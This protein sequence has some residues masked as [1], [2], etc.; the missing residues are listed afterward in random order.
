MKTIGVI[1]PN[2]NSGI[3]IKKCL[4]SLLEQEYKVNEIIVVDDCSTDESTKIVK[5]YT[6]K[7]D[8]IILLENGKNMGVSY[9]R[10]RGI[11]NAKSE[12]IMFCDSDDW[13]EKQ[14]TKR[15]M[16]KVEKDSADFVLAGYYIT[17]KDG[18]KIEVKYNNLNKIEIDKETAISY[19]PITSSS[20]LIK[21]SIL[22]EHNIKYP[23]G[24]KNC[25]ELPVIPVAGFYA[26]KVVYIDEC[27]YNY[28]QRENS[29]SN[30]ELQ[31][32]SFYDITY[33]KFKSNLPKEY[34][35]SINIRMIE[36]LLYGKTYSLIKEKH[37]KKEIIENINKCKRDLGGQDI[38][39]I[40]MQFPIRK[41]IFV[42]CALAK[43]IF[44]L[45]LYVELQQKM[46]EK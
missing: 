40:L 30:H 25:E 17:Y 38:N 23:E 22:E 1:V 18:R 10:N 3:Y 4:D 15:M 41:R 24:I 11:E 2:Y 37:L 13:Y 16:E 34:K 12:Y 14:A 21:K 8:N 20:K 26:K 5:E 27:L 42:K 29:A 39:S 44:P 35:N 19:L 31:D 43:L 36:H 9:S 33:E 6:E 28:F 32:L 46:I 7:N 45:K